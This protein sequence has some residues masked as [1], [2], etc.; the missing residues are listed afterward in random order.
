MSAIAK[1]Y[2][3]AGMTN[4]LA[5]D[6]TGKYIISLGP[7]T[8]LDGTGGEVAIQQYW[9]KNT[10]DEIY[11]NVT[12]TESGDTENRISYSR[13]NVT[14]LQSLSFGNIDPNASVTF[15]IKV[16]VLSNSTNGRF[17]VPIKFSG[18]TI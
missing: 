4:E 6:G 14:Y 12:L 10:G 7:D 18:R 1:F 5:K 13:D 17:T 9:M 16:E 2:T 11:Q 15:Y 3:N 8:G